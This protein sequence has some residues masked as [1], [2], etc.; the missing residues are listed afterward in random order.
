[1][2]DCCFDSLIGLSKKN[3][4]CFTD[5]RP[6]G[7]NRSDSGYHLTDTDFGLTVMDQCELAGWTLL[8]S[9]KDQAIIEVKEDL[10]A[11][12]REKYNSG[13]S[14]FN[15]IISGLTSSGTQAATKSTIGLRIRTK[16]QKGAVLVIKKIYLGL[17]A[18]GQQSLTISSNDPLFEPFT[19]SVSSQ[20]GLFKENDPLESVELPL[21]S[22][23]CNEK[24][25]EYY[26]SIPRGGSMPLNNKVTCCG[27]RP[28]WLNHID[29]SGFEADD[30]KAT[31]GNFSSMAYGMAIDCYLACD[32]LG[33]L[34]EVEKLGGYYVKSV[35]ARAIQERSAAIAISAL[36][37][38]IQVNPCTGYQIENLMGKRNFLNK[39]AADNVLW[40]SQNVPNG[41]T[42]CFSCKPSG[43]FHRSKQLV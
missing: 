27:A 34:C 21:Y 1:M 28:A 17:N 12:L 13:I 8:Q 9:A 22:R 30:S 3:F 43:T 37:D 40:L 33:W 31:G 36:I 6:P 2:S 11:L 14:P 24:W 20:A 35:F 10:R 23:T 41:V 29:V 25:L 18:T 26:I 5:T 19:I 16:N 32:E 15:G 7:Y 39:K 42:D 4:A 38:T